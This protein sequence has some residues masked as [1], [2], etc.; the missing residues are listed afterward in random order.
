MRDLRSFF[1]FFGPEN[2]DSILL[3]TNAN[4][5]KKN[6]KKTSRKRRLRSSFLQSERNV[7][8][9]FVVPQ[10]SPPDARLLA[11]VRELPCP[12]F[13]AV[14]KASIGCS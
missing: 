1:A 3:K 12:A 4:E 5:G 6:G 2:V 9:G 13:T 10:T 8:R 14:E 11:L 7:D